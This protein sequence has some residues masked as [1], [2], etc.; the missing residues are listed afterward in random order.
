MIADGLAAKVGT[1]RKE[2]KLTF[3][4][5][6]KK[7]GSSKSYIWELENRMV[8]RPSAEKLARIAQALGVTTEYLVDDAQTEP[9]DSVVKD[10]FF[11]KFQQLSADEQK[12]IIDIVDM[13]S[14]Q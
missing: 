7:V 14:R 9:D 2:K 11:R 3:E 4:R 6:S 10:A 8:K 1:L 12:K 5:L 13:W